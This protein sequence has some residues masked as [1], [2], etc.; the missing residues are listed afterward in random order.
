MPLLTDKSRFSE[1]ARILQ[2][3]KPNELIGTFEEMGRRYEGDL[4]KILPVLM[5]QEAYTRREWTQSVRDGAAF[6]STV[7]TATGDATHFAQA[8]VF[9]N[10]A[11]GGGGFRV[12]IHRASCYMTTAADNVGVWLITSDP[13]LASSTPVSLNTG[14]QGGALQIAVGTSIKAEA[15][16]VAAGFLSSLIEQ[17]PS[18]A[19]NTNFSALQTGGDD[20]L[21]ELSPGG[22]LFFQTKTAQAETITA[23]F[24]F[25]VYPDDGSY[26]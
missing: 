26:P 5:A 1:L 12:L 8:G 25:A 2:L 20:F 19:V 14:T 18:L 24:F 6:A 22:G 9:N 7:L 23:Q 3:A 16:A 17:S 4:E 11:T 13:A 21:V 10:S 15:G